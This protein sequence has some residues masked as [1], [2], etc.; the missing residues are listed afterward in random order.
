M[1]EVLPRHIC[2]AVEGLKLEILREKLN[3]GLLNLVKLRGDP[4]ALESY[5]DHTKQVHTRDQLESS[6]GSTNLAT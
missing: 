1:Y 6:L 4:V 5:S 2:S 3:T